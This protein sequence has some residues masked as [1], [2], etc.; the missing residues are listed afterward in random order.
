M[1]L[2]SVV[3]QVG[4]VIPGFFKKLAAKKDF[5]TMISLLLFFVAA[6]GFAYADNTGFI[7]NIFVCLIATIVLL[8]IGI[9]A[10]FNVIK[11]MKE[12]KDTTFLPFGPAMAI[13]A[14]V[15]LFCL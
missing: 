3:V 1:L 10:C 2:L 7:E 15:W 12:D 4:I 5:N 13:G 8:A 6:A 11:G 14:F 9:Y